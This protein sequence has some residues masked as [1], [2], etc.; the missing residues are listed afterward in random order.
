MIRVC[1]KSVLI[2]SWWL[3]ILHLGYSGEPENHGKYSGSHTWFEA[4]V[5]RPDF[6]HQSHEDSELRKERHLVQRNVCA[7]S[8]ARKHYN[9]WDFRGPSLETKNWFAGIKPGDVVALYPRAQFPG[10]MNYVESSTM[11]L[12]HSLV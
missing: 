8:N 1:Y 9:E 10:W 3:I 6:N 2:T 11:E 4:G 5:L 7:E 12:W